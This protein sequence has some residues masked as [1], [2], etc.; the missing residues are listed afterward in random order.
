MKT[1]ILIAVIFILSFL[2]SCTK[3]ETPITQNGSNSKEYVLDENEKAL[4][5]ELDKYITPVNGS[6][7]A[8]ENSDLTI[9]DKFA[10]ASV[11]GLGE[12]THGTK[13]FFEMKHRVIKYFIE[14]HGFRIVGFEADMGECIY[15]DR[16]ITKGI[17]TIDD[18]MKKMHFWTW[19]TEEVKNLILWMKDYNSGKSESNQIHLLGV[20]CQFTNYN[21]TLIDEYLNKYNIN[22]PEY[23]NRIIN[24]LS[25][26]KSDDVKN[27][28]S[29]LFEGLREKCDSVTAFF[30]LNRNDMVKK[31]GS[32]EFSIIR[33]L[34]VQYG[35]FLG[36]Y[37]TQDTYPWRDINMAENTIWLTTLL[38]GRTKVLSWAHNDHVARIQTMFINGSQGYHLSKEFGNSYKVIGFSFE[39]GS[40]RA[41]GFDNSGNS[42]GLNQQTIDQLPLRN[43]LNYVF[44]GANPK[45]FILIFS[46]LPESG[47]L[48]YWLKSTKKFLSFGAGYHPNSYSVNYTSSALIPYFDAIIHFQKTNSA[49]PY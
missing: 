44:Y 29:D 41:V 1:S 18:V 11:I 47:I 22:T 26:I 38:S 23:V 24:K 21:K 46:N 48:T 36:N 45:D 37:R 10:D 42:T 12:A 9:L 31:S 34:T 40:F 16:F 5:I 27:I 4:V 49:V 3:D 8:L 7:P 14:K 30:A 17:G 32:F 33:Q 19:R 25:E 2:S 43:S 28:R 6:S 15:I 20:D 13:E 39:Q 35:Q